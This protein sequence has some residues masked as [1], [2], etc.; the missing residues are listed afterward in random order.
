MINWKKIA[1]TLAGEVVRGK[2]ENVVKV[3]D[4]ITKDTKQRD[5]LRNIILSNI[6]KRKSY[7]DRYERLKKEVGQLALIKESGGR[8]TTFQEKKLN[9]FAQLTIP[10]RETM[11]IRFDSSWL[12]WAKY[13]PSSKT[14]FIAMKNG[15]IIYPFFRVP[16]TK[17][18]MLEEING[19]FMW[20]YFGK[21]YSANPSHWIRRK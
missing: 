12:L 7:S 19:K 3:L 1:N 11:E 17:V 18:L 16:K 13:I 14:L 6:S 10:E 20:D 4:F 9:L 2:V 5:R 21:H 8:L 15:K